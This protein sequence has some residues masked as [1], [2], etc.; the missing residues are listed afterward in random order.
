MATT[1]TLS[2]PGI[3]S[4]LDV[5]GIVAK[6]MSVER[7]P[8]DQL[9][10]Q[11]TTVQS[12]ISAYGSLKSGLAA[13]QTAV[14]ALSAP[15]PFRSMAA[16]VGNASVVTAT[17][18][19]GAVAGRYSLEVSALAQSHKLASNGFAAVTNTVGSGALTFTFG[20]FAAGT[21]TPNASAGARTVTIA[22]GQSSLSGIRDAVNAAGV[23][24]T[25]T[26]VNDGTANGQR[27]VFTSNAS[28]A[29]QSLK[30][31][32]SDS[33]GV[34]T[35]ATGLSQLAYDPAAAVG[36]GK[37]LVEKVAAQD[38]T[39]TLDGIAIRSSSN[40]VTGAIAGVT[41]NL[42]G[43]NVGSPTSV[44][45]SQD[46]GPAGAAVAA[47]IKAYNDLQTT[48]TSLTKY[49]ATN[50]TPSVLTGDSTV[51][52]VQAQLRALVGSAV[53][54]AT[55]GL[56]SMS[57]VGITT[58]TDG[59]LVL[60]SAK[61]NAALTANPGAVAQLF[62]AT[63]NATDGW[64]SFASASSKTVAGTYAVNVTQLAT[65]GVLAGS[66]VAG[67]TI[68]A[69]SNDA[70]TATVDGV[71]VSVTLDAA[72]YASAAALAA[73]VAAKINGALS[74]GTSGSAVTIA[75]SAGVLTLTSKRFGSASAVALSGSAATTLVGAA[76][77]ATSG[78]DVAGTIGG[79]AA[80]GSGQSLVG[81]AGTAVDGLA[82]GITGGSLGAR[83]TITYTQGIGYGLDQVLTGLLGTDGAV[84]ARTD[85]LQSTI[86]DMDKRKAAMQ[87]RLDQVQA[88]YLKQYNALDAELAQ[89]SAISTYLTQQ[90]ANLPKFT[91]SSG[92]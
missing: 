43:T 41:L 3:G 58:Q 4:G 25:A 46:I 47:F 81:A 51:R 57:L 49:D 44:T 6:L 32:V 40:T 24:V 66:A 45:V 37:N 84:Q 27:L 77:T 16:T 54:G 70:L 88:V 8:L 18:G 39:F 15:T 69:G 53:A 64:V 62:A 76:P 61:F 68:T 34:N 48:I 19:A 78:V 71:S 67:L 26:I 74:Q 89:M 55:S 22:A 30:I 31:T 50:K 10:M 85:G 9:T 79:F 73:Q 2:S 72:T 83:G 28:G 75:D 36:S 86:T 11:E 42:A 59:T 65:Q 12:K 20:T 33:D 63:G 87:A 91:T 90:L 92:K 29:D 60:D 1:P 21:F 80:L 82:L 17:T 52:M 35:D 14:H 23:G 13:L 7:R 38:A 56:N 5:N